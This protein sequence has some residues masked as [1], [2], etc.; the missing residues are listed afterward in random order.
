MTNGISIEA[1]TP[2]GV[3]IK[4]RLESGGVAALDHRLQ[5]LIPA[6]IGERAIPRLRFLIIRKRP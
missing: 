4:I 1:G 3:R 5:A 2:A 6:G